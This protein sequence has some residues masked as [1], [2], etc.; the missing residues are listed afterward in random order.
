MTSRRTPKQGR[1]RQRAIRS[2]AAQAG[3]PYLA[4][5]RQLELAGL[6]P[7]EAL[8]AFGRT[9]Y[10]AGA[11]SFRRETVERRRQR[12][13]AERV[14]DTRRAAVLPHGRAEHLAERFP[15]TRGLPGTGVGPLYHGEDRRELL[16]MLYL[17]VA[18]ESPGLIPAVGDLAWIAEMGEETALD[19]ACA[20]LDRDAR[21]VADRRP[22]ALWPAV[23]RALLLSARSG[24]WQLRQ[25]ATRLGT[26][27]RTLT[28]PFESLGGEP[29]AEEPPLDG[30]RQILDAVLIVAED[31]HAPGTRI[32]LIGEPHRDR[33][34]TI[35]GAMWGASGP[36]IGYTVRP[37][38][39]GTAINAGPGDLVVLAD[40]ESLTR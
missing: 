17:V 19:T 32:R 22:A 23:E 12:S 9:V 16:T 8:A 34:G 18:A 28:S 37:D 33:I 35:V 25:A 26:L 40:Q 11:D 15:P 30:V 1:A 38:D 20:A 24:D 5:A 3:V 21:S 6:R 13:L 36:P 2:Q 4:A 10:P 27:F 14:A 39:A 7:G 31:G 29:Y